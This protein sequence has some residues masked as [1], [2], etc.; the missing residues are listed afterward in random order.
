MSREGSSESS[1]VSVCCLFTRTG[2]RMFRPMFQSTSGPTGYP[3]WISFVGV[4]F[5]LN[6]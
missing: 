3:E 4:L 5:G 1:S 6:V 2:T